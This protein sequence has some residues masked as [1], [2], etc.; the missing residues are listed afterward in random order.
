MASRTV[1]ACVSGMSTAQ[2]HVVKPTIPTPAFGPFPAGESACGG[3]L[4]RYTAMARHHFDI[5]AV[6]VSR[7]IC[8]LT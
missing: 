2:S 7:T 8:D 3:F 1:G 5:D 6:S 4:G